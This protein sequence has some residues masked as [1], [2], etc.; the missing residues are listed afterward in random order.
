M[1]VLNSSTTS[2]HAQR[3]AANLSSASLASPAG[4]ASG[5][6]ASQKA[7]T[8]IALLCSL[9]GREMLLLFV[10]CPSAEDQSALSCHPAVKELAEHS[11]KYAPESSAHRMLC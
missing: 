8:P 10:D 11:V 4:P 9:S 2:Q 3:K 7:E 5:Q 6:S 1:Q